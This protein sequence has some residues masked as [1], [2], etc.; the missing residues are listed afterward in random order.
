MEAHQVE[1]VRRFNR[2]V[3]QRIGALQA[4][5][6]ARGRPLGEARLIY[7]TGLDGADARTLRARLGLDSGYLSRML[8]SLEAQ[9]LVSLQPHP[10]D[11]RRRQIVLT[12]QGKLEFAA[13][14]RLSDQLAGSILAPLDAGERER[15][16]GAMAEVER[17]LRKGAVSIAVEPPETA[18]ARWCLAEYYRELAERFDTGYDPAKGD[19]IDASEMRPPAGYFVLARLHGEPVGCGVLKCTTAEIKRVWTAPAARGIG[20]ARRVLHE[21]EDLARKSGLHTVRLDTNRTLTEARALYRREGYR[22]RPAFNENPY[23]HYWFEK[24]L[25]CERER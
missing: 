14:G 4:S 3:T 19:V 7:E 24:Q 10:A 5:Y 18:E 11:G 1:R 16:V 15:L 8:R 17:L 21:L 23:A 12:A 2:T 9:G 20:V 6:L 13:Y 22:E 25:S